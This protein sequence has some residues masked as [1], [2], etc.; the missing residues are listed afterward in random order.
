M[1]TQKTRPCGPTYRTDG[2]M[3]KDEVLEFP[4]FK[5]TDQASFTKCTAVSNQ[6]IAFS[7]ADGLLCV[8]KLECTMS[9]AQIVPGS[10]GGPVVDEAGRLVGIASNTDGVISG[11]VPLPDIHNILKGR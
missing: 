3:L 1:G 6:H 8:I 7:T 5:V 10:S 9:S 4:M 2:E 11:L